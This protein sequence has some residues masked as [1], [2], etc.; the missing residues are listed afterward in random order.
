MLDSR[1]G[2]NSLSS[3]MFQIFNVSSDRLPIILMSY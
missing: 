1:L 2:S 3:M